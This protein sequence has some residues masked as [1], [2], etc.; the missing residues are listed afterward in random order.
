MWLKINLISEK[1]RFIAGNFYADISSPSQ[2][3]N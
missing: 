2:L 3:E 1:W